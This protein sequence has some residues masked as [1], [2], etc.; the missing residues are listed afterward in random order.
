MTIT[1]KIEN[2]D[3]SYRIIDINSSVRNL[4][5]IALDINFGNNINTSKNLNIEGFNINFSSDKTNYDTEK[6]Y[7]YRSNCNR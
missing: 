7:K 2:S 6:Q 3:E 4:G 1:D 5:N